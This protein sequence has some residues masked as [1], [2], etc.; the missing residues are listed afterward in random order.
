MDHHQIEKDIRHLEQV[1]AHISGAECIPLSHWRARID[2]I[3]AAVRVPAQLRRVRR[4]DEMLKQ[5][6]MRCA[7]PRFSC[8]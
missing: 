4:L 1:L 2:A 3:H 8:A 5:L 7:P 6:E